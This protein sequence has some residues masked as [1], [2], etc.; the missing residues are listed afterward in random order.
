MSEEFFVPN[1]QSMQFRLDKIIEAVEKGILGDVLRHEDAKR[2]S[3][4]K[5]KPYYNAIETEKAYAYYWRQFKE[6]EKLPI[7]PQLEQVLELF[8]DISCRFDPPTY[9]EEVYFYADELG[10]PSMEELYSEEPPFVDLTFFDSQSNLILSQAKMM[11]LYRAIQE[12]MIYLLKM[13]PRKKKTNKKQKNMDIEK[14]KKSSASS[15]KGKFEEAVKKMNKEVHDDVFDCY[16]PDYVLEPPDEEFE[17]AFDESNKVDLEPEEVPTITLKPV[18][19]K[20]TSLSQLHLKLFGYLHL[21]KQTIETKTKEADLYSALGRLYD[22]IDKENGGYIDDLAIPPGDYEFSVLSEKWG[23]WPEYGKRKD[24]RIL[25]YFLERVEKLTDT[26]DWV[27]KMGDEVEIT[28]GWSWEPV[29]GI[30]PAL[31]IMDSLLGAIRVEMRFIHRQALI[32]NGEDIPKHKFPKCTAYYDEDK[33][34]VI[35]KREYVC[36]DDFDKSE[37]V[38]PWDEVDENPE[39]EQQHEEMPH[40]NLDIPD[41]KLLGMLKELK[42]MKWKHKRLEEVG[43]V[44]SS[45]TDAEWLYAHKGLDKNRESAQRKL[46]WKAVYLCKEYVD[47]LF[48]KDKD[49]ELAEKVF[50]W[51]D[52]EGLYDIKDLKHSKIRRNDA[53]PSAALAKIAKIIDSHR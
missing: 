2:R 42:E 5:S 32:V 39:S 12:H 48:G 34:D 10:S 13:Y 53:N 11:F 19:R 35:I 22:F 4:K 47:L 17:S 36:D 30:Y 41:D 23:L 15:P 16:P 52:K 7:K 44:D 8:V 40:F 3:S 31:V 29:A 27:T 18:E 51:M 6:Y 25:K 33:D 45:I 14:D 21:A 26:G 9:G 1:E 20:A 37:Y 49:Y 46:P 43:A 50:C 28:E 24:T 38:C